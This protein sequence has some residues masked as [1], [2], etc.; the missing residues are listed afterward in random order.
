GKPYHFK[1]KVSVDSSEEMVAKFLAILKRVKSQRSILDGMET[2]TYE[3]D[4]TEYFA[5]GE[6]HYTRLEEVKADD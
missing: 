1:I 5:T 3:I 2:K 6:V 4:V